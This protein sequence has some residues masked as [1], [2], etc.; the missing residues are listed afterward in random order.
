MISYI[1]SVLASVAIWRCTAGSHADAVGVGFPKRLLMNACFLWNRLS[2]AEGVPGLA[3]DC[4]ACI[5]CIH[6]SFPW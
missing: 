6:Q 2:H 5:A 3:H 1:R 4:T